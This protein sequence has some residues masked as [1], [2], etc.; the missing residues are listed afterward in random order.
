MPTASTARI[1]YEESQTAV[2]ITELTNQG[3]NLDFRSADELWS[4]A[5]G[6]EPTVT[7]NGLYDG[8]RITVAASGSNDVVD[9]SQARVYIAGVLTTISASV[10]EAIARPTLSHI[11]YSIQMTSGGAFSVVAGAEHTA[12]SDTRGAN[13]G[14]PYV[15]VDST[16]LGQIHLSSATPAA[17]TATEIKQV[18]GTHT[19]RF[20]RPTWSVKHANVSSGIL[21]YAGILFNSALPLIHTGDV[22]KDVYASWYTPEFAE[23]NRAYD[24]VPP[25]T[26]VSVNSTQVY[27]EVVGEVSESIGAGSFTALMDT[28]ISDPILAKTGKTIWFKY[29]QNRLNTTVYQICQGRL[30]DT[31]ANPAGANINASF[32]LGAETKALDIYA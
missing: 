19:E 20:D 6:F 30:G 17:I 1:Q 8:G 13:G 9:I 3:D 2:A 15:L 28:N 12:F 24:W 31:R 22:P 27:N 18:V 26:S 7:P 4:A 11:K 21:G 16:E 25:S 14:P 29:W 23:I 5:E 10:D 32:T